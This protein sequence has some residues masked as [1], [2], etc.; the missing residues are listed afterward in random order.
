MSDSPSL[1]RAAERACAA[2]SLAAVF[3]RRVPGKAA[4]RYAMKCSAAAKELRAIL[5]PA[6]I[7]GGARG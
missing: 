4:A 2:L 1:R 7:A 3:L 6:P 5:G